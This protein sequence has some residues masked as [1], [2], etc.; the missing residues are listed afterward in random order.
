MFK[1][2]WTA[3][4]CKENSILKKRAFTLIELLVVIA[5]IALLLAILMPGLNL[6]KQ[7]AKKLVCL[8]N[9]KQIGIGLTSY[10]VDNDQK[11]PL[12]PGE[13]GNGV[14]YFYLKKQN[15]L[16]DDILNYVGDNPEIFVC[17]LSPA[18]P[19]DRT[20]R[21]PKQGR[22]NFCYMGNYNNTTLNYVSPVKRSTA[23]GMNGLWSEHT[24][25]VGSSNGYI[26][27]SHVK[28][29]E[30][31]KFPNTPARRNEYSLSYSQWSL[32]DEKNITG[33]SCLFVDGS[34]RELKL[35]QMYYKKTSYGGN[36]Y[37]PARGYMPNN[38]DPR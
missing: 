1:L 18:E 17:P 14:P 19:P 2:S 37:P 31:G 25:D 4:I 30:L 38:S 26:R 24:A 29:S 35:E 15:N 3:V 8:S 27:A 36:W 32:T 7:K 34:S 33:V 21:E 11:F 13:G 12:F 23:S 28:R 5:I 6:A 20:L 22:W 9:H 10:T 16:A